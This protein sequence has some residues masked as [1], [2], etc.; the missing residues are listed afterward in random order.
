MGNVRQ[1][2]LYVPPALRERGSPGFLL[3]RISGGINQ[4]AMA[5]DVQ[6]PQIP[7]AEYG[8]LSAAER[9]AII[10]AEKEK[11]RQNLARRIVGMGTTDMDMN[12]L[13]KLDI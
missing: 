13:F 3:D 6:A 10:D 11:K 4:L 7:G 1:P 5:E 2:L 8:E 9:A 12:S